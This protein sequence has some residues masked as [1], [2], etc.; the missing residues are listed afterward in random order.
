MGVVLALAAALAYGFGDFVGGVASRRTRPWPVAFLA[1]VGGLAGAVV[2]AVA[3]PGDATRTDLLWGLLAGVGSGAGTVFL[4]RGLSAGRMGV[5]APVSGVGAAL[6]PV[7]VGLAL[8]ERPATLVWLGIALALPAIWLV[9]HVPDDG[10]SATGGD[11]SG[12]T[13]IVDGVFAGLGFG[14]IFVAMGMVADGAGY[15]PLAINQGMSLVV[16]AV[17]GTVLRESWIPDHSSQWWGFV[18]GLLA[19]AAVLAFL[20]ATRTGLLSVAAVLTSFY[21]AVT[22]VL[23]AAVLRERVLRLQLVGLVLSAAAVGLIAGG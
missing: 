13:G 11:E 19:T 10:G 5:V 9:A 3:L 23:A 18:A 2:L 22:V 12:S 8:G 1:G 7:A 4:Y 14:L 6:L 17:A 16:I 21:P 20:L 15:W